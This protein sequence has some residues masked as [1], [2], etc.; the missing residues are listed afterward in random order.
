MTTTHATLSSMARDATAVPTDDELWR[1]FR[2]AAIALGADRDEVVREVFADLCA[3]YTSAARTYHSLEHIAA[4]LTLLEEVRRTLES[5]AEVVLAVWF[6]DAVYETQ[7]HGESEERS[8]ELARTS[9]ERMGID[10]AAADRIAAMVLAT[11][12]HELPSGGDGVSDRVRVGDALTFFDIDLA[13]LGAPPSRYARYE[14]EI[15]AEYAWVPR[16]IF[17]SERAKVLLRFLDRASIY[18]TD[19]LREKLEA[20][21]RTNLARAVSALRDDGAP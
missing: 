17:R 1:G 14:E 8:A 7:P 2:D 15:R 20:Q 12:S 6:H 10:R 16:E 19:H 11:K 3:A 4:S 5:P 21:A 9:A 18:R 13:I